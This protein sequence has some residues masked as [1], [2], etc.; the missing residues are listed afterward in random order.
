MDIYFKATEESFAAEK[1]QMLDRVKELRAGW[2]EVIE[3]DRITSQKCSELNNLKNILS[4]NH[5]QILRTREEMLNAEFTNAQLQF[6]NRLLQ[7]EIWRLLPYAETDKSTTDYRVNIDLSQFQKPVVSKVVPDEKFATELKTILQKWKDLKQIQKEVF[8]EEKSLRKKDDETFKNFLNDYLKQI[9]AD[10]KQIDFHLDEMTHKIS[11]DRTSNVES[12]SQYKALIASLDRKRESLLNR[13]AEMDTELSEKKMKI[14]NAA[15][16]KS[17]ALCNAARERVRQ[18]ERKN[19]QKLEAL[20]SEDAELLEMSKDKA[21]VV[22]KLKAKE[23]RLK[24]ANKGF[25]AEGK[26]KIFDL[27]CKLNALVSA[28]AS[29]KLCPLEEHQNILSAV[30]S[31]VQTHSEKVMVFDEMSLKVKNMTSAINK[32]AQAL[33]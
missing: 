33:A 1:A 17:S 22:K 31:A 27:E 21:L 24:R 7:N 25:A 4:K 9:E 3:L 13:M 28:A 10:H 19:S 8:E 18:I 14:R 29:M 23:K 12:T 5:I 32:L 2:D 11:N 6:Q 15:Q 16:K 20:R 26:K 30:S